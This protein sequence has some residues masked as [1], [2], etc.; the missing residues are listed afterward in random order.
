VSK[1]LRTSSMCAK[2]LTVLWNALFPPAVLTAIVKE[3]S[4]AS[5]SL[6]QEYQ[7]IRRGLTAE[8]AVE[9]GLEC[10]AGHKH[11]LYTENASFCGGMV[12]CLAGEGVSI[13]DQSELV[14]QA[15]SQ[16]CNARDGLAGPL[17]AC[18]ANDHLLLQ[19]QGRHNA[20]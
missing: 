8:A 15:R 14:T 17:E 16:T 1:G 3:R 6:Y 18:F 19:A 7:G 2:S 9:P 12:C 4:E 10:E 5:P 13:Y 20:Y 11:K